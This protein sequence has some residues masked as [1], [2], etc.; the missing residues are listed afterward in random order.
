MLSFPIFPIISSEIE[1]LS[2]LNSNGEPVVPNM[3]IERSI[4]FFWYFVADMAA[5]YSPLYDYFV[6]RGIIF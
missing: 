5:L 6:P 4:L 2:R 3:F 1:L